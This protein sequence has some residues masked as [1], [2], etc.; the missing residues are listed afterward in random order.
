MVIAF[1]SL[2]VKGALLARLLFDAQGLEER[3]CTQLHEAELSDGLKELETLRVK[4]FDLFGTA[5]RP[6]KPFAVSLGCRNNLCNGFIERGIVLSTAQTKRK[7][8]SLTPIKITSMPGIAAIS[9]IR[10]TPVASSITR[11][12]ENIGVG[13]V[14]V[15]AQRQAKW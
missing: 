7:E 9:S 4:T 8:R 10:S 5:C 14:V 6:A 3:F 11:S 1:A 12:Q 15:I 2:L 13:G